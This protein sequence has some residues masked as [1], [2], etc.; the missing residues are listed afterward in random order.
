M[1]KYYARRLAAFSAFVMFEGNNEPAA[2]PV[3][4]RRTATIRR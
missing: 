3:M 1:Q 2:D 4:C